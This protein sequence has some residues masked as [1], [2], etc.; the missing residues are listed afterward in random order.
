MS[1]GK[2]WTTKTGEKIRIKDLTDSHLLNILK[3]L[4]RA[5]SGQDNIMCGYAS[6]LT[7]EIATYYADRAVEE[8][9]DET[10]E[11]RFPI[12]EHLHTEAIRRKLL[13][14]ENPYEN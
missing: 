5:K 4:E 7:G 3:L 13:V 2:M 8:A 9:M 10:V 11:E 12:Y 6:M 14:E 1:N